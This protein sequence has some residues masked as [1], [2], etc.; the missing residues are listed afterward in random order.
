MFKVTAVAASSLRLSPISSNQIAT[1]PNP[2]SNQPRVANWPRD[3]SL[4]L[5][6]AKGKRH[7]W[8]DLQ[9][10]HLWGLMSLK[11][12]GI[13]SFFASQ[14][15]YIR[16]LKPLVYVKL[17]NIKNFLSFNLIFLSSFLLFLFFYHYFKHLILI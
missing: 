14:E 11:D 15:F 9:A 8:D 12:F 5:A 10:Q 6:I 17:V 13:R 1:R 16:S 3:R 4:D 2:A 7:R